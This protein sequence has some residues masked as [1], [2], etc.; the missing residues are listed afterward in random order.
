MSLSDQVPVEERNL[1]QLV[2]AVETWRGDECP[3]RVGTVSSLP[4]RRA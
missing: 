4:V 3:D 2:A 1:L